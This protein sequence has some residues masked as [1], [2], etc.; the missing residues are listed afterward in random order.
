[1]KLPSIFNAIEYT[2]DERKYIELSRSH[3]AWLFKQHLENAQNR[4]NI[5][6]R[7]KEC[8]KDGL[9]VEITQLQVCH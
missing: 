4:N 2:D 5:R 9:E 8:D 7:L 6:L 1:M 3:M